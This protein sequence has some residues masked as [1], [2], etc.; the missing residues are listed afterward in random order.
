MLTITILLSIAIFFVGFNTI[1]LYQ[2]VFGQQAT[3]SPQISMNPAN[4]K[5]QEQ[6]AWLLTEP[7]PNSGQA[8][9]LVTGSNDLANMLVPIAISAGVTYLNKYKTDKEVKQVNAKTQ[10][11]SNEI[12]KGKEVSAEQNRVMF[13]LA[14]DDKVAAMEG[15]APM[16][17][18][19]V[20]Q[21]DKKQFAE[22][23]IKNKTMEPPK[24]T[25]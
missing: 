25:D 10:D 8:Q 3:T 1:I 22:K 4:L 15:T 17:K 5:F 2:S 24:D 6:K 9:Q 13:Q 21:D 19:Q 18:N 20:L 12:L 11:N 16:I 23:I 7:P 14:P